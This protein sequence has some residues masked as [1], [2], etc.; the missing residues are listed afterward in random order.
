MARSSIDE[1]DA[2]FFAN[3]FLCVVMVSSVVRYS[4]PVQ[5]KGEQMEKLVVINY[6]QTFLFSTN[7][8]WSR[9]N[10]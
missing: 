8:S 4:V 7:E 1:L 3:I 2:V 5:C 10:V 6:E 9:N